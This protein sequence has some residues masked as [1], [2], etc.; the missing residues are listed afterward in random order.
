MQ[1][2]YPCSQSPRAY[3]FSCFQCSDAPHSPYFFLP[4]LPVRF[5]FLMPHVLLVSP[6]PCTL[7]AS[8]FQCSDAPHALLSKAAKPHTSVPCARKFTA[9][10]SRNRKHAHIHAP[11]A[12]TH[13]P[14]CKPAH[15]HAH[16][17]ASEAADSPMK[18]CCIQSDCSHAY[19]GSGSHAESR[20]LLTSIQQ[21]TV[22]HAPHARFHGLGKVVQA[23]C[24]RAL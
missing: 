16:T 21:R 2:P 4:M 1:S 14:S 15:T 5:L 7:F 22:G 13:A 10:D 23:Q 20:K 6:Y 17:H 18:T 8:C 11:P 19:V 9:P 12:H 3:S 24:K